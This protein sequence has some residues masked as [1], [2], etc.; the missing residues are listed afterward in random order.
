MTG[1]SGLLV[2]DFPMQ[3]QQWNRSSRQTQPITVL[4]EGSNSGMVT[5]AILSSSTT[6]S[7]I[8]LKG[9]H[10]GWFKSGDKLVLGGRELLEH[11]CVG[12]L[13]REKDTGH[14]HVYVKLSDLS[15]F[16]VSTAAGQSFTYRNPSGQS[17]SSQKSALTT[18]LAEPSNPKSSPSSK[19][20]V[21]RGQIL[22]GDSPLDLTSSGNCDSVVHLVIRRPRVECQVHK[23]S[24][25]LV[26][27]SDD[28][29]QSI[30]E[31]VEAYHGLP[32]DSHSLVWQGQRLSA[33]KSLASYGVGEGSV[34]EL[35][36]VEPVD[37]PEGSP[38][39]SSPDHD[40][41]EGWLKARAGLAAGQAPKLAAAGTGGSYF[42][43]DAEGK[44]VAVFKPEDEEPMAVNNPKGHC[45]GG[46]EG[47]RRGVAPGEGAV[48]EVAAFL[49][50]HGHFSGVPPTALV[51]CHEMSTLANPEVPLAA[52][53]GSLQAFVASESDCEERGTAIFCTEEVHKIAILDIR[54]ANCDR[55]GGN[56]L[57]QRREGDRTCGWTLVPI[58]H[59]YCLP[60]S[61]ADLEWEW[62]WWP[63]A[64][65]PFSQKSKEYIAALDVDRDQE[66]LAAHGLQLR[67]EC[68]RVR[69]VCT[70]LLKK[71]VALDWTPAAIAGVMCRESLQKSAL[72]K[73]HSH[74]LSRCKAQAGG[75]EVEE[76]VYLRLM[77]AA[78]DELLV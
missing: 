16:T 31:R 10:Q 67:P 55:N 34:L 76:S 35:V 38:V 62:R 17:I 18:S 65:K 13:P 58:D 42:I 9:R 21:V 50:D 36:P 56:I 77:S 78:L 25:E 28:D 26:I 20:L 32:A 22:E 33:T 43:A 1:T 11:E 30:K 14:L 71:A 23:D 54:I 2:E 24:F 46:T 4:F 19:S 60:S 12:H 6:I 37:L 53:I 45:S 70:M 48:R 61:F 57:V 8:K 47:Y 66:T 68:N 5:K 75:G 72:E 27:T 15:S 59:G 49:L 73:V 29:V 44:N 39:L 69:K 63:Q 3:L 64:Q 41:Y 74:V 7:Q 51:S 52:K 40:L